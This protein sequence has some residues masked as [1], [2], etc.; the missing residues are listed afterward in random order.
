M[1][2]ERLNGRKWWRIVVL[3]AAM[4]LQLALV[5]YNDAGRRHGGLL[6]IL[7]LML[8]SMLAATGVIQLPRGTNIP[9]FGVWPRLSDSVKALLSFALIF[10]WSPIAVR[11][12]PDSYVGVAI[13]LVPDGVF[14]LAAL[15]YVSNGLSANLK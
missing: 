2:V 14:M 11:L 1:P 13:V 6:T 3:A 4:A 5:W 8:L 12:V 9:F 15:V 10:V 7:F